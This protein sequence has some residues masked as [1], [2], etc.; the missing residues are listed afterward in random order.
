MNILG[1]K[2]FNKWIRLWTAKRKL[3]PLARTNLHA[4]D[5][6]NPNASSRSHRFVVVDLETTGMDHKRDRVVSVGAFRVVNGRIKLGE[7]FDEL[8]NPGRRIPVESI[9]VHAIL[10]DMART[11]RMAWEVFE[12]F[13]VFL[14]NDILVAHHARFD[15]FFINRVMR[16]QH[17]F[18][19]QNLVVDTVLMCRHTLLDPDPYG[20]RRGAKSCSLDALTDRY[21]LD[22]PERHT[23]IGD[24]LATSLIFQRLLHDMERA[25][26]GSLKDLIRVAG[27]W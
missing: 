2:L 19:L 15:L 7:V 4:L 24:A 25:G 17:G 18:R 3:R 13:L 8:I 27:V 26:W 23:A 5:D 21:G 6:L 1:P 10:P 22:V 12:D 14:G 9:H 16:E 20:Q 11:A